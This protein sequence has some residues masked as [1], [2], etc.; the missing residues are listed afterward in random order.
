MSDKIYAC[1]LRL[2]PGSF[3]DAYG[4]DALQLF[5]DRLREETGILR[6]T[7]LWFDIFLDLAI[8]LP[9]LHIKP[10]R[11]FAAAP[12]AHSA[13]APIFLI[14]EDAPL[15]PAALLSGCAITLAVVG[16]LAVSLNQAGV[17]PLIR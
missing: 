12:V 2:F 7:R 1:L 15:R 5:Q 4:K 9:R 13:S 3:R 11:A 16:L 17:L 8:S 10:E 14:L 6:R